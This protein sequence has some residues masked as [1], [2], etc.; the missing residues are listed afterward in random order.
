[1]RTQ[2]AL[3]A[4][5]HARVKQKAASLGIT[6]AEY[7]RRLVDRDLA[8]AGPAGDPSSIIGI[9]RSGGSDIASEGKSRVA[10]AVA[11]A[12][13]ARRSGRT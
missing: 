3:D 4:E 12:V 10:D 2:I 1:M 8:A 13:A 9:G 5:Q 6:M 11:D 7:I